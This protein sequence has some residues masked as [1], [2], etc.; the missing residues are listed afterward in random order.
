MMDRQAYLI[1][2]HHQ[3]ELLALLCQMLDHPQHDIYIHVDKKAQNFQPER[4]AGAV[5][6]SRLYFVERGQVSWGGYSQIRTELRLLKAAQENGPYAYYHLLSGA[7][8]PLRSAQALYNFFEEHKGQEFVHFCTPAYSDGPQTTNRVRYYYLFQDR[9][10]RN[11][12]VHDIFYR[13]QHACLTV[14]KKLGTNRL[15][16][17]KRTIRCGGQWFSITQA[18]AEYVLSQKK[19]I[20]KTFSNTSCSDELFLQTLVYNSDFRQALYM[21]NDQSDY[22][23]CLRYIDWQ[24]GAPYTFTS[25]DYEDL[26]GSDYLF[27]RKFDW[28]KDEAICRKI[29]KYVCQQA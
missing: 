4:L 12:D 20:K 2:A 11:R 16:H 10:G 15:A 3:F 23:S 19:W 22:H 26:I 21:P 17:Q 27:A 28:E 9:V 24:R 7:D 1:I 13:V 14:Q 5:K 18:L 25:A 6:L 8:L 29:Y